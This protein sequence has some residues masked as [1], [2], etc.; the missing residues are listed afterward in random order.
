MPQKYKHGN[1]LLDKEP[2]YKGIVRAAT[3]KKSF[4]YDNKY[5]IGQVKKS[6]EAMVPKVPEEMKKKL[7]DAQTKAMTKI[8]AKKGKKY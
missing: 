6:A 8:N 2:A 4:A 1:E 3:E 5:M 7:A